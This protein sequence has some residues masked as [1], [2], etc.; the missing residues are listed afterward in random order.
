MDKEKFIIVFNN[1]SNGISVSD[2]DFNGV[3][4]MLRIRG[5]VNNDFVIDEKKSQSQ[6]ILNGVYEN[7]L[8]F[9]KIYLGQ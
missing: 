3:I 7:M 6:N 1:I 5:V 4:D 8:K 9:Y 2:E